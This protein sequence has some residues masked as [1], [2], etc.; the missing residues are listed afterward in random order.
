MKFYTNIFQ[1]SIEKI[2]A[3]FESDIMGNF[4]EVLIISHSILL[5]MRNVSDRTC[6]ENKN[7]HFMF[8]NFFSKIVLFMR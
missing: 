3:S 6:R 1:K 7:I 4:H 2:Q 5:C 8:S